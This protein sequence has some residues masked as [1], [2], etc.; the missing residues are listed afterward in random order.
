MGA[1]GAGLGGRAGSGMPA[2][3]PRCG[4][5]APAN[6]GGRRPPPQP[7]PAYRRGREHEGAPST[8]SPNLFGGGL[9]WGHW[10]RSP[11]LELLA[12]RQALA[13][14]G[15]A[16]ALAIELVGLGDQALIDHP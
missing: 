10:A 2:I 13:L 11:A 15:G 8:P 9:G 7:S 16:D 3:L 4:A 1:W 5:G 6:S 14:V 12:E